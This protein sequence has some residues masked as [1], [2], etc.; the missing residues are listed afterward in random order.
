MI[1]L[2]SSAAVDYLAGLEPSEWVAEQLL[3][4]PDLHAPHLID[5][6]VAGALRRLAAAGWFSATRAHR[7]LDDLADLGVTRYPHVPL[8]ERIW[9]LR[10]SLTVADAAFVALAEGLRATLVTTDGALA[11]APGHRAQVRTP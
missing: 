1:V 3:A 11:R 2:D 6:E 4:D 5:I 7:A 8:L 10:A 9:E